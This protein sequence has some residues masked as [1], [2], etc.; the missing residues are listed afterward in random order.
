ME[1]SKCY[2]NG[3]Q[4]ISMGWIVSLLYYYV[5]NEYD[6]NLVSKYSPSNV[7]NEINTNHNKGSHKYLNYFTT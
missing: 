2:F 1:P 4:N 3:L 7:L 6:N 5:L